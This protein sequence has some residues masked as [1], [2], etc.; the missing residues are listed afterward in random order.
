[1]TNYFH[2]LWSID[3]SEMLLFVA[4]YWLSKTI[5]RTFGEADIDC[6]VIITAS[7]SQWC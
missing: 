6:V 2:N 3:K 4:T 7:T 5:V 1:M